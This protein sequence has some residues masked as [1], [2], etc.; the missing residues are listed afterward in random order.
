MPHRRSQLLARGLTALALAR[1]AVGV[2]M[3]VRPPAL[4]GL[5]GADRAATRDA[6]WAVQMLGAREVALGLGALSARRR[7]RR[8]LVA[9][10]LSDAVDAAVITRAAGAGVLRRGPALL[11]V[12]AA[13]TAAATQAAGLALRPL[14]ARTWL[15]R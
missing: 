8:W 5:L 15:R 3:L 13:S 11:V 7:D 2:A 14:P 10:L 4:G 12:A 6:D 1:T 9:G